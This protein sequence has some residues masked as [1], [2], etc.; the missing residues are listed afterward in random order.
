MNIVP[1]AGY[2]LVKKLK[3]EVGKR[4]ELFVATEE[5]EVWRG[6]V[7]RVSTEAM[8][9]K[10]GDHI[11]FVGDQKGCRLVDPAENLYLVEAS[12]VWGTVS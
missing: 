3:H 11:L 4:G 2:L 8:V 12:T 7:L 10:R 1:L 9:A 5:P 6:E